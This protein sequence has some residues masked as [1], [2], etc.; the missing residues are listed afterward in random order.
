VYEALIG[1][2]LNKTDMTAMRRYTNY[3]GDYYD[4]AHYNRY[5][6]LTAE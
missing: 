6:Q 5:G 4:Q 3:H 2:V 1:T